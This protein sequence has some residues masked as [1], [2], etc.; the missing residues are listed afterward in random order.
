MATK[1]RLKNVEDRRRME[2]LK[3]QMEKQAAYDLER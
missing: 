1:R 3:G 2:E